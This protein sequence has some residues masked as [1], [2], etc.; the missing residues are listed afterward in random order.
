MFPSAQFQPAQVHRATSP[1]RDEQR[2][3]GNDHHG[4]DDPAARQWLVE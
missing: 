1:R 3:T 4:G 2:H